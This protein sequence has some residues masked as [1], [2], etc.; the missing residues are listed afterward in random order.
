MLKGE[1]LIQRLKKLDDGIARAVPIM[2][3]SCAGE[4]AKILEMI[5][6]DK[7]DFEEARHL[8]LKD[9]NPKAFSKLE[10]EKPLL[11][12]EPDAEPFPTSKGI[13]KKATKGKKS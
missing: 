3:R 11:E 10:L 6:T 8:L 1:R 7:G 9:E 13:K 2:E 4:A 12:D 5:M